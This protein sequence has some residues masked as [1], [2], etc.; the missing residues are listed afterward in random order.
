MLRDIPQIML[1][2]G[3]F[4]PHSRS[5]DEAATFDTVCGAGANAAKCPLQMVAKPVT[6]GLAPLH[7]RSARPFATRRAYEVG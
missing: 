1:A 4:A 2:C 6:V 7:A 3:A 5:E